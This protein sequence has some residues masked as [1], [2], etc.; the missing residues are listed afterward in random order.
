MTKHSRLP[1]TSFV[2]SLFH[3]A[4]P[5]ACPF[6]IQKKTPQSPAQPLDISDAPS[7]AA[8]HTTLRSLLPVATAK[9]LLI[10]FFRVS[11]ASPHT[12]T[13]SS[14]GNKSSFEQSQPLQTTDRQTTFSIDSAAR[15]LRSR[16]RITLRFSSFKQAVNVRRSIL[17]LSRNT[18]RL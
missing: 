17:L 4:D 13:A 3:F 5:R 16:R 9:H 11:F 8:T 2:Q 7:C 1:F 12:C 14:D 18:L 15:S 10:E 6:Y